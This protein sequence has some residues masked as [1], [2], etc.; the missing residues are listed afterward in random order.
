MPDVTEDSDGTDLTVTGAETSPEN[1][2][3]RVERLLRDMTLEEK[4]A[5]LV[6]LWQS[7]G[8]AGTDV[9]APLQDAMESPERSFEEFA[10]H[11]LGQLTRPFG[12]RPVEPLDG[13]RRVAAAQRWLVDHTR[14]GIPARRRRLRHRLPPDAAP[15]RKLARRRRPAGVDCR[16]RRGAAHG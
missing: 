1:G 5:Q 15:R 16:G 12:T 9:V 10:A 2:I 14:M 8:A 3:A 6:A 4:L 7:L 11:G 13:A